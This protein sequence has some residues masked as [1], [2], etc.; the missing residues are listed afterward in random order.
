MGNNPDF[1]NYV[2]QQL[3]LK[4]NIID[5]YDENYINTLI[6]GYYTQVQADSLLN[7]KHK[8]ILVYY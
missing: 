2:N 7:V 8:L 3:L 1:F 4:R 5:S 6:T